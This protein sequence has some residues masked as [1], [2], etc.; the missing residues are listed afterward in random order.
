[1]CVTQARAL[2][3]NTPL[4]HHEPPFAS[5]ITTTRRLWKQRGTVRWRVEVLLLLLPPVQPPPLKALRRLQHRVPSCTQHP[6]SAAPSLAVPGVVRGALAS[7]QAPQRSVATANG[8]FLCLFV[9]VFVL[10]VNVLP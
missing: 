3:L 1:M 8:V 5:Q 6:T 7:S 2:W 4:T 9:F 10:N